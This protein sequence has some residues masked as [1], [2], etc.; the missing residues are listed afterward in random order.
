MGRAACRAGDPCTA[1]ADCLAGLTCNQNTKKCEMVFVCTSDSQCD[2][3]RNPICTSPDKCVCIDGSCQPRACAGD[4]ACPGG[5]ICQGGSCQ[6]KPAATGLS[7]NILTPPAVIHQGQTIAFAASAKNS[8]GAIVP[9]QT[10][11]W[12]SSMSGVASIDTNSGV[13]T[14]G[15]T[16]GTTNITCLVVGGSTT[17][18]SP[19]VLQNY[20]PVDAGKVRVVVSDD[21]SGAPVATATVIFEDSNGQQIGGGPVTTDTSG[22]AQVTGTPPVNVHVFKS[23][24]HYVSVIGTTSTDLLLPLVQVPSTTTAGGFQGTF[25][26]TA[27]CDPMVR[28]D[29]DTV[30]FG[31]A[32]ASLAGSFTDLDFPK[33]IGVSL[34]TRIKFGMIYDMTQNVPSGIVLNLAGQTPPIK[35]TYEA[36]AS[37][38]LHHAWGIGGL[39]PFD[40]VATVLIPLLGSGGGTSNL[41]IGQILVGVLPLLSKF[42]HFVKVDQLITEGPEVVDVNDINGNGNTT[43]LVPD[44]SNTTAF[45]TLVAKVTV[46]LSLSTAVTVPMLPKYNNKFL[47]GAIVLAGANATG[48][49]LV[50]L[51][52]SA[53]LDAPM[54]GEMPDGMV[55][56]NPI[57]FKMS[58]LHDGLEGSRYFIATL[59]LSL[60]TTSGVPPAISG[61]ITQPSTIA[62][63]TPLSVNAFLGFPTTGALNLDSRKF[64]LGD[65]SGVG[66]ANF[67]RADFTGS[68]GAKWVVYF[69]APATGD[70]FTLPAPPAGDFQDRAVATAGCSGGA[71]KCTAL[72][73]FSLSVGANGSETAPSFDELM[74][75]GGK[76]LS[77]LNDFVTGFSNTACQAG[78]SCAPAN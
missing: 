40:Q 18:S 12:S 2:A 60:T 5:Q 36:I 68:G 27:I 59:A 78:G 52:I 20:G 66:A 58:P 71:A 1:N 44:F 65:T 73:V 6:T 9:G 13:A 26:F 64:N 61:I 76:N 55:D 33:L 41:P 43:E 17:P 70:A 30:Q 63:T 42:R 57:S 72:R 31:I 38:G 46:P 28:T 50:P 16:T 56:S 22:I 54:M 75:F 10:F 62:T 69:K 37:P 45:P 3:T 47:E 77:R 25:D 34:K 15:A 32:G 67:Y 53:G 35:G 14:G 74:T 8:N 19:V 49:G 29:C 48:R 51:G 39:A 23:G 21:R 24:Y 11:T 7:C 4:S